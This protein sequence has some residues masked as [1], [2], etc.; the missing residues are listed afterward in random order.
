MLVPAALGAFPIATAEARI[1]TKAPL[2][3]RTGSTLA[4]LGGVTASLID[5]QP[6]VVAVDTVSDVLI[7]S[8][9]T[10]TDITWHADEDGN[11]TVVADVPGQPF[12]EGMN[13]TTGTTLESG[14]YTAPAQHTT[15]VS[16]STLLETLDPIRVCVTDGAG[17]LGRETVYVVKDVTAPAVKVDSV[18]DTLIGSAD[19]GTDI[20]WHADK[21][22][23]YSVRVGGDSCATGIAVESG[24]YVL[25]PSRQ[26]TTV[27]AGDLGEGANTIRICVDDMFGNGGAVTTGVD[28]DT[29]APTVAIDNVSDTLIGPGDSGTDV[30]WHADEDG[31][32][33]VRVG[34]DSCTNGAQV[35]EGSYTGAPAQQVTTVSTGDLQEGDNTIRICVTDTAGNSGSDTRSVAKDTTAP[36]VAIDAVSDPLVGPAAPAT[37]ISWHADES[38]P[39]SVRAGGSSC[40]TGQ[41]LASGTYD[42][43]PDQQTTTVDADQLVEGSNTVR[44]CVADALGNEGADTRTVVK[45]TTA[46]TV[47]IDNVSDTLIVPGD[48]GTDVTWHADEDGAYSVRVGGDSCTNGAQAQEG[49]YTGAPAQ[50][51]TTVSTGDLQEG[52]N[53]IRI[54]VT[55]AA[56]NSGSHSTS[57]TKDSVVTLTFNAQADARVEEANPNSNFGTSS[58]LRVEGGS[59]LDTESYLR[60]QVTGVLGIVQH[61]TLRLWV[62]NGTS[63]GPAAFKTDWTGAETAI[64]WNNRT[65]RTSGPTDDKGAI[66]ANAFV[67]YDVTPLVTGNGLNGFVLATSSSDSLIVSSREASTVSQQAA[68]DPD[69][70]RP[71]H[72]YRAAHG[73]DRAHGRGLLAHRGRP[74][75][76]RG[77]GQ[78]RRHGVPH[79]PQRRAPHNGR[80]RDP[81]RGHDGAGEHALR[82]RG[83]GPRCGPERLRSQQRLRGDNATTDLRPGH[84]GRRGPGL[85]PHRQLL[86][87]R[88]RHI[89]LLQA[90]VHVGSAREPRSRGRAGA[91]GHP[92]RVR[93]LQRLP[94]FLRS[95]LGPGQVGHLPGP[96]QP[97]VPRGGGMDCDP[98]GQ[99]LGYFNYFGAAAGDPDK[100]YYSFNV[101]AW[102]LIALNSNCAQVSCSASS[103]Q[104]NWLRQDLTANPHTCTLAFWH[105]PRFT[106]GTNSPGSTLVKPLYQALYDYRA[107]VVL[108]GHDHDYER[109]ALKDPD[110]ALDAAGI[111]QFVVGTGGKSFHNFGDVQP[112]SE[113]RNN[114]TFGVLKMILGPTSY[115][116]RFIPEAGKTYTDSGSTNCTV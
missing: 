53:T 25:P 81:L 106:S 3:V 43:P 40:T 78:H 58:Q 28:K 19:A 46:P 8:A 82:V 68:A 20:S 14:T 107:D 57:V 54:C 30:T 13:C 52:D 4:G 74:Q 60:F 51:V 100:G 34:G 48:S 88:P 55:D 1:T 77:H 109:F 38:G 63:N 113:A 41:E 62:T 44:V 12:S 69:G 97:R 45:D 108:V 50:Q 104:V 110:G 102:H 91:R 71:G 10:G 99:A 37:D 85:R 116:W 64:T 87:Q 49:S 76:G 112:G 23:T 66:P 36:A 11:Y 84:H 31:A 15:S 98:T 70:A 75:L 114:D 72:G 29:I 16:A 105:H 22:A 33:S 17:N 9:D 93:R 35:Q 89:H 32:Y 67:D 5:T 65:A 115:E 95:D 103:A 47:A 18:S 92:V 96:W 83:A 21:G 80:R 61:A 86:Q 42:G 2:N 6:P 24:H 94:W 73:A 79:R 111:R 27:A 59:A 90:E 26:T 39:Y 101:G 56:G 7:G